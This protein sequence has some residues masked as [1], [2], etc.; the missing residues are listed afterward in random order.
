M[1]DK[2]DQTGITIE[3]EMMMSMVGMIVKLRRLR[4]GSSTELQE[5]KKNGGINIR[6]KL[7][8]LRKEGVIWKT[9]GRH[10][11]RKGVQESSFVGSA[12]HVAVRAVLCKS[13][14][15]GAV[16]NPALDIR[17]QCTA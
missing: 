16:S 12:R 2:R 15:V 5:V 9:Q 8:S 17:K 4:H 10:V 14:T 6:G 11:A 13:P 1:F 7:N 3:L